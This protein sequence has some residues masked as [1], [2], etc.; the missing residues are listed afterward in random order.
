MASEPHF[1]VENLGRGIEHQPERRFWR[2]QRDIMSVHAIVAGPPE[3]WRLLWRI[4]LQERQV[5]TGCN[6]GLLRCGGCGGAGKGA[7][8]AADGDRI[9]AE[10]QR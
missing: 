6:A 2:E 10:I 5:Q 4:V 9:S 1:E 8:F 7:V 3:A